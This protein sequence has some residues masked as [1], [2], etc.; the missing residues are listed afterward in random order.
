MSAVSPGFAS[1]QELVEARTSCRAYDPERP[2]PRPL[3]LECF[4]AARLAPSACNRQ[5]W[6][7][8]IVDDPEQLE[9]LRAQARLPGITHSWWQ[10]VPVFVALC[11]IRDLLT[12]RIAP[13]FSGIPYHLL[14]VGSAGEH[15]ILAATERGLGSCWI[16]W[17]RERRV[18]RILDIPHSV[19]VLALISIGY[20]AAATGP[21]ATRLAVEDLTHWNRWGQT[22]RNR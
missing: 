21:R 8:V 11:A 22:D 6:R 9:A 12:H 14:D 16:G 20:P 4:A 7:F 2:V 18:K 19:R 15:F 17:S 5:P 1:F 10:E 13:C 3:L